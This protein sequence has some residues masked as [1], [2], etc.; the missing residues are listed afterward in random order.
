MKITNY[1]G[2]RVRLG[3]L[4]V[5]IAG[6]LYVINYAVFH[7][8]HDLFFYLGIDIA[9]LPIEV[10]FVV[11]VI[12][13]AISEREKSILLE[14]LN[15]VI[16]TFFSEVGTQLVKNVS[17]YDSKLERIR[18]NLLITDDWSGSD[19]LDASRQMQDYNYH[20]NMAGNE[21]SMEFLQYL[22]EFLVG[23]RNFLLTLLENPNLL[24][25]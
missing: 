7:D 13:S 6:T 15:M 19:F 25:H 2:W 9:F 24:E 12:E 5:L 8:S 17:E 21:D 22:K 16:G 18:S 20:L 3:I 10:L 1:L 14:K 11:L 4:L 23:K